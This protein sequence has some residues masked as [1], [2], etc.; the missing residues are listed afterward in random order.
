MLKLQIFFLN[1][2]HQNE[3]GIDHV[4][5]YTHMHIYMYLSIYM[6]LNHITPS[7]TG[8]QTCAIPSKM[9]HAEREEV[10]T[11]QGDRI[12]RTTR[13]VRGECP[14]APGA[15][16]GGTSCAKLARSP[17]QMAPNSGAP[18]VY[19]QKGNYVHRPSPNYLPFACCLCPSKGRIS[20]LSSTLLSA[21]RDS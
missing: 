20:D 7:L 1:D 6:L 19:V 10:C 21:F 8:F 4:Y 9:K 17:L 16:P 18:H 5:M 2:K 12:T 11:G 3:G 13:R 14:R 15:G